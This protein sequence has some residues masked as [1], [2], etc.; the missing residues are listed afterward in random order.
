MILSLM[1][2]MIVSISTGECTNPTLTLHTKRG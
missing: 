2:A 1:A